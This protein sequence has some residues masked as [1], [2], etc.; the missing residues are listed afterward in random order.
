MYLPV[1]VHPSVAYRVQLVCWNI[2]GELAMHLFFSIQYSIGFSHKKIEIQVQPDFLMDH[3]CNCKLSYSD[4]STDKT[5]TAWQ[6][7]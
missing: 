4:F 2:G 1:E 7:S 3:G 6:M 5:F